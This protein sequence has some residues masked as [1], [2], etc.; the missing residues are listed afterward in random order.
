MTAPKM[1]T[2]KIRPI[3]LPIPPFLGGSNLPFGLSK[4]PPLISIGGVVPAPSVLTPAV[5][6]ITSFGLAI[7]PTTSGLDTGDSVVAGATGSVTCA[8]CGLETGSGFT[9]ATTGCST[10]CTVGCATG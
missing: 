4:F 1:A 7:V 10:D 3:I 9:G 8:G 2:I 6:A 5:A